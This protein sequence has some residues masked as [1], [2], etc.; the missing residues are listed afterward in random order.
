MIF[1]W[2]RNCILIKSKGSSCKFSR[3]TLY[4]SGFEPITLEC[5]DCVSCQRRYP[6]HYQWGHWLKILKLGKLWNYII[7]LGSPFSALGLNSWTYRNQFGTLKLKLKFSWWNGNRTKLKVMIFWFRNWN[8]FESE[9][10]LALLDE[11]PGIGIAVWRWFDYLRLVTPLIFTGFPVVRWICEYHPNKKTQ[12]FLFD[13]SNQQKN[14]PKKHM[15]LKNTRHPEDK[16]EIWR[17]RMHKDLIL[18][19][20][21]F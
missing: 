7:E 21:N 14:K 20:K 18:S 13:N 8:V 17:R 12:I 11:F 1:F 4:E 16:R 19:D 5:K 3:H 2:S 6:L 15:W 9:S 10:Q